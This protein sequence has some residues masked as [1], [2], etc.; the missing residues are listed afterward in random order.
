MRYGYRK[1]HKTGHVTTFLQT[2][3]DLPTR[4]RTSEKRS[5]V[6]KMVFSNRAEEFIRLVQ[7]IMTREWILGSYSV[8]RRVALDFGQ[9]NYSVTGRRKTS[10]KRSSKKAP[11][12]AGGLKYNN[13]PTEAKRIASKAIA[14]AAKSVLDYTID[15]F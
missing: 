10:S 3:R 6:A 2:C 5:D 1:N 7:P 4:G 14:K 12:G 8:S 9:I 11:A 13:R 15:D